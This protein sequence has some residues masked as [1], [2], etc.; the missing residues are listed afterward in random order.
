MEGHVAERGHHLEAC[1]RRLLVLRHQAGLTQAGRAAETAQANS[2]HP[3]K[4]RAPRGFCNPRLR[5]SL[6]CDKEKQYLFVRLAN[7]AADGPEGAAPELLQHL[8]ALHDGGRCGTRASANGA[9]DA[10]PQGTERTAMLMPA[11]PN[12]ALFASPASAPHA[13]AFP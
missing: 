3:K 5:R 4:A 11:S 9:G 12:S 7:D 8:V 13:P 2:S 1:C 6:H 10:M